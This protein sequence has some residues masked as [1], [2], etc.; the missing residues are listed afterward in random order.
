MKVN[1]EKIYLTLQK[2]KIEIF[3][4]MC[5]SKLEHQ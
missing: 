5:T 3:L 2:I 4:H 1:E